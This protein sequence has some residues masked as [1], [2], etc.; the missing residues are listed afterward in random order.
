[1]EYGM[2]AGLIVRNYEKLRVKG[3]KAIMNLRKWFFHRRKEHPAT[4]LHVCHTAEDD[5]LFSILSRYH[6]IVRLN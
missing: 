3:G 5:M 4:T 1:V 6:K 2:V